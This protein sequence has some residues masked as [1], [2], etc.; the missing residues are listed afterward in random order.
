MKTY[1]AIFTGSMEALAR[2]RALP[3]AEQHARQREGMQAWHAWA[4]KHQGSIVS[5]GSPLGSTKRVSPEG[6]S[7]TRNNIGAYTVVR[8][9]SHDA[10]AQLF[11]GHP[12]FTL[13]PG[14]AVEVMECLPIPGAG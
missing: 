13:F 12:H 4:A 2:F 7:D 5:L 1:V 8:A 10:A 9:E 6:I 11:V 14:D 3:E